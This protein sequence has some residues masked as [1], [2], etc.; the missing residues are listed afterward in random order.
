MSSGHNTVA[1][2]PIAMAVSR[3][4]TVAAISKY[5]CSNNYNTK[6]TKRPAAARVS[7]PMHVATH[8]PWKRSVA[9]HN[10]DAVDARSKQCESDMQSFLNHL[11]CHHVYFI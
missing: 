2:A 1:G 9:V 3:V 11:V 7:A 8:F 6:K 5:I 4:Q 10:D